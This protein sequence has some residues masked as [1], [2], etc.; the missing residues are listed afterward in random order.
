MRPWNVFFFHFFVS[1]PS[2]WTHVITIK[3]IYIN[4][5]YIYIWCSKQQATQV[6]TWYRQHH[7]ANIWSLRNTTWQCGLDSRSS[8]YWDATWW[9]LVLIYRRFRTNYRL[10]LQESHMTGVTG[11]PKT[12]VNNLFININQPDALNFLISL[13]IGVMIPETV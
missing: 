5:M 1:F 9:R 4:T 13:F 11:C 10:H 12:S 2:F 8:L 6:Q 3:I 7:M